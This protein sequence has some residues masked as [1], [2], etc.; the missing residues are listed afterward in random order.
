M[1]SIKTVNLL[2]LVLFSFLF[3]SLLSCED[4]QNEVI[5]QPALEL[6]TKVLSMGTQE[7][8]QSIELTAN[9]E[10]EITDIPEW[11][12]ID[13][14]S[15]KGDTQ[16]NIIVEETR[17]PESREAQ[18]NIVRDKLVRT[19]TVKQ[20]GLKDVI[21]LPR[22]PIFQ[23]SKIQYELNKGQTE[24][25]Y[26]FEADNIFV[27]P[28][29]RDRIYLGNLVSYS[30]ESNTDIPVFEGYT[31]NPITIWVPA[32][33]AEVKTY[34]P[35]L[36][37]QNGFA[38]QVVELKPTQT[39]LL[40]ADNGTTEFFTHEQLYT[41]GVSNLGVKL[42]ELV[43]G[44]SYLESEMQKKYGLIYCYKQVLF[45]FIMDVPVPKLVKED[46]KEADK[47]KGISYIHTVDYGKVGLL[48]VE[49]DT[50][51]RLVRVAINK[52][53]M[54]ASLSQEETGLIN[55]A[56]IFYVYF[57]NDNQ[58]QVKKERWDALTAYRDA[59]KETDTVY[60]VGFTVTGL[61]D[62]AFNTLSFSLKV[63]IKQ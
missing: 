48:I 41:I 14:V 25:Q 35:S 39:D 47:A 44:R 46:I 52:M 36:E 61:A 63:P 19:L 6:S 18:I 32:P 15:G 21:D 56:D 60:P 5:E 45:S 8:I 31:F 59:Y 9:G 13:P 22:L 49:S 4:D 55:A 7:E 30:A 3:I 34:L 12:S 42:D 62:N 17:E 43:S 26:R 11:V 10:W 53:M 27:N 16:I 57:D 51:S 37:E 50:D 24:K 58:V 54:D 23:F 29:I 1:K 38:R 2:G 33:V 28:D 40:V 20:Y